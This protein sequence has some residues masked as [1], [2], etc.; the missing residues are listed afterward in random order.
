M[1]GQEACRVRNNEENRDDKQTFEQ[2]V[3]G[4]GNKVE[5]KAGV[6]G[7]LFL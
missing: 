7:L 6:I 2:D 4:F 5:K 1:Y 3:P